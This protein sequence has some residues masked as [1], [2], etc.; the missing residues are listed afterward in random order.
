MSVA[1]VASVASVNTVYP[2]TVKTYTAVDPAGTKLTITIERCSSCECTRTKTGKFS[3]ILS[4]RSDGCRD[5]RSHPV[6]PHFAPN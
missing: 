5:Y 6:C 3:W 4:T 2:V 1:S